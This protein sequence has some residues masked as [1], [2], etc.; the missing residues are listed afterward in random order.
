MDFSVHTETSP[1]TP[2]SQTVKWDAARGKWGV[3][4][5]LQQPEARAA[6][7][8]D[9]QAGAYY[10]I[11]PSLR[12]GGSLAFGE[13]QVAPGSKPNVADPGQPRVQLETKFK[14]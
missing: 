3:M 6:T 10:R 11:T 9:I 14:F 12:V 2:G 1:I 7:A 8:N 13:E 5:N 4:L